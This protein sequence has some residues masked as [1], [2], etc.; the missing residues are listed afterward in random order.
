MKREW[1]SE[2]FGKPLLQNYCPVTVKKKLLLSLSTLTGNSI[3]TVIYIFMYIG[4]PQFDR[5]FAWIGN[6]HV[7]ERQREV[8]GKKGVRRGG[9]DGEKER[10][11][12]DRIL[13]FVREK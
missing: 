5:N 12:D 7:H 9:K 11:M 13:L 1:M 8:G 4:L 10:E 2:N 3:D 6:V